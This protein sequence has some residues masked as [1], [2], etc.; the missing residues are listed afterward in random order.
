[1]AV[2][3]LTSIAPPAPHGPAAKED[4]AQLL[5]EEPQGD[6]Q[7]G[8]P[9]VPHGTAAKAVS[10]CSK[11]ESGS[12]RDPKE[13]PR[14]ATH[15]C[16]ASASSSCWPAEASRATSST[17]CSPMQLRGGGMGDGERLQR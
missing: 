14:K 11:V 5:T 9:L 8:D 6:A 17:R 13:M 7:E 1:M 3:R 16:P 15:L 2:T 12:P 10:I 4:S